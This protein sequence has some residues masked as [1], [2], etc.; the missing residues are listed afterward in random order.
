MG[1]NFLEWLKGQPPEAQ[2]AVLGT[3]AQAQ[4]N[5][6][7]QAQTPTPESPPV[8]ARTR[9]DEN[10]LGPIAEL[11]ELQQQLAD[12]K[13]ATAL[14]NRQVAQAQAETFFSDQVHAGRMMPAEVEGAKALYLSLASQPQLLEGYK[15]TVTS[16]PS[17]GLFTE[18]LQ[19]G[20]AEEAVVLPSTRAD[21]KDPN[22]LP[23]KQRN[24]ELLEM[25]S[26]GQ[27]GIEVGVNAKYNGKMPHYPP[28][29][30]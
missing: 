13:A 7:A 18:S 10:V 24:E 8:A 19:T 22:A 9:E 3:Q 30:L 21:R 16:R 26:L 6:Q 12:Q 23:T 1:F 20:K 14:A 25:T 15:R 17:H 2:A 4:P 29:E 28:A 5:T 11:A 27:R